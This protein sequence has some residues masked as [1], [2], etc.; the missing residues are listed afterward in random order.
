MNQGIAPAAVLGLALALSP[1][2]SDAQQPPLEP[3]AAQGEAPID[4]S[5]IPAVHNTLYKVPEGAVGWDVLG[6]MDVEVEVLGPLRSVFHVD[7]S[8][9]IKALDGREVK[10]MGFIYPLQAGVAHERFLLTAWPPSCPFCLPAGPSQMV[11]VHAAAPIEFS[12]GAV[13]LGGAFEVLKDDPSGLYY[14]M[15]GARVVERFDDIRWT[16]ELP[17]QPM[18][19]AAQKP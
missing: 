18:A 2:P 17:E 9:A 8:A 12:D 7:Y 5:Q 16:G 13:L 19:P 10:L 15:R 1:W 3:P 14:R 6:E 4:P 11:E